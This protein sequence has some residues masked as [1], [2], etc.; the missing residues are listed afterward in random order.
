MRRGLVLGLVAAASCTPAAGP[1]SVP[2]GNACWPI[3]PL[4]I[5]ERDY[6]Q[7][8][9]PVLTLDAE[10]RVRRKAGTFGLLADDKFDMTMGGSLVCLPNRYVEQ[11]GAKTALHHEPDGA[12]VEGSHR[13]FVAPDGM[14]TFVKGGPGA[15]RVRVIGTLDE[16]TRRTAA[17]LAFAAFL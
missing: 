8:W 5:E 6:G 10:G 2:A 13:V 16:G 14:V 4:R 1:G 3:V 9:E 15:G 7:P 11:N 17:L 12:L